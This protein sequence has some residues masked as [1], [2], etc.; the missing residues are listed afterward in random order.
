[1][2]NLSIKIPIKQMTNHSTQKEINNSSSTPIKKSIKSIRNIINS[3][4]SNHTTKN[5]RNKKQNT[6]KQP[7][8]TTRNQILKDH[9]TNKKQQTF[10]RLMKTIEKK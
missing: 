9:H 5:H 10:L 7:Q 4:I 8:P 1:M 6:K 2:L 3:K